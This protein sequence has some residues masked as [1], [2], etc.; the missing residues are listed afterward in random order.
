[1]CI[2][3]TITVVAVTIEIVTTTILCSLDYINFVSYIRTLMYKGDLTAWEPTQR[4]FKWEVTRTH[5]NQPNTF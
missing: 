4:N 3:T 5:G 1:M 2:V